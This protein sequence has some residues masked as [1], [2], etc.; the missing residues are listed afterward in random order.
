MTKAMDGGSDSSV[1]LEAFNILRTFKRLMLSGISE[2]LLLLMLTSNR[3]PQSKTPT[4]NSCKKLKERSTTFKVLYLKESLCNPAKR[5]RERDS[6]TRANI[7]T[8]DL[9]MSLIVVRSI[10]NSVKLDLHPSSSLVTQRIGLLLAVKSF[11]L[12]NPTMH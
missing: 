1:L 10:D 9:S 3:F 2:I 5:L 8:S 4:G 11:K 6:L 7:S 12:L